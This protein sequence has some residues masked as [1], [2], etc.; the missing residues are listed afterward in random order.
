LRSSFIRIDPAYRRR[1]KRAGLDSVEKILTHM[2][3]DFVAWSRTTDTLFVPAPDN[4]VG[5]YVKRYL[6]P[7]WRNRVRGAFR[8]TL[9]GT[10]R[11]KKE[12]AALM[13]MRRLGVPAVRPVAWGSR[14]VAG[15]LSACFLVTEAVP[16]APN[17]TTVAQ[18][19]EDGLR[20]FSQRERNLLIERLAGEV[21]HMHA[22]QFAHGRLFWR[23]ILLRTGMTGEPDV[24]FLDP[25]P[26]KRF[27]RL[28]RS[29]AWW[30]G[31]LAKLCTSA[32]P[33]TRR[34]E[35]LRFVRHYFGL[36][37]LNAEAKRQIRE[38]TRQAADWSKHEQQR[39]RMNRRFVA[40]NCRLDAEL[41]EAQASGGAA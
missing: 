4:G 32:L 13:T 3:G 24:F 36:P 38:A 7:A 37:R 5:F 23:N 30:L 15:F 39:I 20:G 10:H 6:Y 1:L 25:E 35:R 14:R 11:G 21:R 27:E 16:A 8:G 34:T 33:F 26:P 18:H 12:A 40:W 19:V 28:G 22:M 17:L 2:G 9:F 41:Q 31:E 29:H